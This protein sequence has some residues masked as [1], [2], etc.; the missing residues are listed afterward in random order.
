[1]P[2]HQALAE[3][4]RR[5]LASTDQTLT[6]DLRNLASDLAEL[7]RSADLRLRRCED[8]LRRGLRGEA[9]HMAEIDPP[10][11]EVV[12]AV[13]F[14]GRQQWDELVGMYGLA[15][16]PRIDFQRAAAINQAYADHQVL[17]PLLKEH[18]RLA[19]SRAPL[20]DRLNVLRQLAQ[21][22]RYNSFWVEDMREVEQALVKELVQSGQRAAER[23]DV[24]TLA[25]IITQLEQ[26][27]WSLPPLPTHLQDLRRRYDELA[28]KKA[29]SNLPNLARELV[30]AVQAQNYLAAVAARQRL[31]TEMQRAQVPPSDPIFQR[32]A[33]ALQWMTQQEQEQRDHAAFQQ[34][35]ADF[36]QLLDSPT[37]TLEQL[38]TAYQA[39]EASGFAVPSGVKK[40]YNRLRDEMVGEA[41]DKV[42]FWSQI[43]NSTVLILT[44]PLVAALLVGLLYVIMKML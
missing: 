12:R 40:R 43:F 44:A 21:V 15:V 20:T 33:P 18:R 32:I 4:A 11:L 5:F 19:L 39:L 17:E 28:S 1:M 35:V 14:P 7:S 27:P 22:D 30:K 36:E 6:D 16:G 2:D 42:R 31:E 38:R 23:R 3:A 29:L 41:R 13:N 10:V 24:G 25:A 37:A 34:A 26:T 9:V 8:F